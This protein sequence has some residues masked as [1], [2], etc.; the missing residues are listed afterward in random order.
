MQR[1]LSSCHGLRLPEIHCWRRFI[2]FTGNCHSWSLSYE[3][4]VGESVP[5]NR[6]DLKVSGL[7]IGRIILQF[8]FCNVQLIK[9]SIQIDTS[10]WL[11]MQIFFFL[12]HCRVKPCCL[13][14]LGKFISI[15]CKFGVKVLG[16]L[17]VFWF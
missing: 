11:D 2:L 7:G 3:L 4:F 10:V 16:L 14:W 17:V 13:K 6:G 15:L 5:S 1:F 8:R 9:R 12:A